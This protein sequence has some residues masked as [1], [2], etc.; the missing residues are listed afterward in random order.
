MASCCP[1]ATTNSSSWAAR[2]RALGKPGHVL[3]DLKPGCRTRFARCDL[4]D[5]AYLELFEGT[6]SGDQWRVLDD[7]LG[8]QHA[9]K[10]ISV[11]DR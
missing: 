3:Y 8:G 7:A 2:I 4:P 5:Y 10:R 11:L 9:I 1:S 6:V